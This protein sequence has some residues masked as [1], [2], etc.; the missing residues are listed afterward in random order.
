M[1]GLSYGL[2][3]R[4]YGAVNAGYKVIGASGFVAFRYREYRLF[5][6]A[7]ALSNIGMWALTYGRLWLMHELTDSPL[8]VG[9]VATSSLGPVLLFSI[10]GGVVAD[11]VNRLKLVRVTRAMFAALSLLTG[12]LIASDVIQPWHVF[13][14]SVATGILLSFD[15]PSR[16]AMLPTLVPQH[17]LA[18]GIA[19][20]SI[21]FGGAAIVGPAILAPLVDLWGL[22]GV[23]FLIGAAY[24]LTV[25]AL[26]FMN[27]HGHRPEKRP[28]TVLQGLTEGCGYL[29]RNPII[30]GV[31]ALGVIAG[32]FGNSFEALLPV[33]SDKILSG[34]ID[35]YSR[36]LLSAGIGGLAATMIVAVLGVRVHPARFLVVAGFGS[37]LGLLVLSR[38]AW[39]P[40]AAV[41]IGLIGAF[42]VVFN[43][44]GIT[45]IQILTAD[46]FRGRVM[47]IHQFT[48]GATALG[49]L[50][51][52]GMGETVGVPAALGLGGLVVAAAT[53]VVALTTLRQLLARSS[54]PPAESI[55]SGRPDRA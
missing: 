15:I 54:E 8:M 42:Q 29:R 21:V 37:G 40:G 2:G 49:G 26:A 33:Y 24:A 52:G 19:L 38:L 10:W 51:M 23:F 46:E 7:A 30:T 11:Q 45:V 22:E 12:I 25:V 17:H 55:P 4:R 50:L 18:S 28:A 36:L 35:T 6:L 27:P 53:V 44:M 48:W 20:Y 14:I 32:I 41:S 1:S 16:S 34:D 31:I 13:T 5:W 39:F 3:H 43:I 47:S 9:L